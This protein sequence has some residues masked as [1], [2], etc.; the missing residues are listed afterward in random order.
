MSPISIPLKCTCENS[1]GT[2]SLASKKN[3]R[4]YHQFSCFL[5]L[6]ALVHRLSITRVLLRLIGSEGWERWRKTGQSHASNQSHHE[7]LSS[8]ALKLE[9]IPNVESDGEEN[10]DIFTVH[11]HCTYTSIYNIFLFFFP[12]SKG[13]KYRYP[14]MQKSMSTVNNH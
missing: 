13:I 9:H 5:F 12:I 14:N 1:Q 7:L 4:F 3:W 6:L 11:K 8:S 2:W 10:E